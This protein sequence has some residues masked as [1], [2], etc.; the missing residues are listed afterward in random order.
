MEIWEGHSQKGLAVKE[1]D[2][3]YFDIRQPP[4]QIYGACS[5]D[6]YFSRLPEDTAKAASGGVHT[7]GSRPP[8]YGFALPP[9]PPMWP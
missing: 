5:T 4:F 9:I 8:A 6:R 7:H 3:E 2:V 1:I